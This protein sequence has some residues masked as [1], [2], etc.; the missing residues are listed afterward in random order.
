MSNDKLLDSRDVTAA[1]GFL[2]R[3]PVRVDGDWAMGR[4]ARS[5]WAYPV[6]GLV[7]GAGLAAVVWLAAVVGLPNIIAAAIGLGAITFATGALHED[8]L[9]D[10]ADGFW[11]GYDRA[12]RLE[13][14]KDSRIGAY[15]V[16]ALVLTVLVS[17]L[18][19]A[20]LAE[21]GQLWALVAMPAVS[22]AVMPALMRLPHARPNGVSVAVG[23][24][25]FETACLSVA[26]GAVA[27]IPL[28]LAGLAV[29][30]LI[31]LASGGLAALAFR[32]IGGQTGDVLGASQQLTQ[33]LGWLVVVAL[34]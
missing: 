34:A 17:W 32:K 4:G 3:L 11:G 22:R 8:G 21:R 18:A 28:G 10:T 9:A 26:I 1:L 5:A 29:G 6:A 31:A 19:I 20:E 25:P 14:M 7:I 15:G 16:L 13:I 24:P 2:T 27:L 12:R 23:R 30:I 33:A